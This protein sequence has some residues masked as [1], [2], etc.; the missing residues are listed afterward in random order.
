MDSLTTAVSLAWLPSGGDV[1]ATELRRSRI[2]SG[3][4]GSPRGSL[5]EPASRCGE[6]VAGAGASLGMGAAD[7]VDVAGAAGAD[8][9]D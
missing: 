6:V 4:A 7:A 2:C 3:C 8:D 5:A 1:S 9:G